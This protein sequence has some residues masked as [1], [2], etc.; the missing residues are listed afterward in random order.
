VRCGVRDRGSAPKAVKKEMGCAPGDLVSIAV[1]ET[2]PGTGN[3]YNYESHLH[4]RGMTV[5]EIRDNTWSRQQQMCAYFRHVELF[6]YTNPPH[7]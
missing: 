3:L 2:P 6:I 5:E 7:S 1:A 4:H